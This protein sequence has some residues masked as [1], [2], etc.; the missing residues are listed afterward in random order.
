VRRHRVFADGACDNGS[1]R[2]VSDAASPAPLTAP[3]Q[4]GE[5]YYERTKAVDLEVFARDPAAHGE[6]RKLP[7]TAAS[8]PFADSVD[9][10]RID[11]LT[12]EADLEAALASPRAL[13]LYFIAPWYVG[14]TEVMKQSHA[15]AFSGVLIVAPRRPSS[16]P[17]PARARSTQCA[18]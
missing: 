16:P 5:H 18:C 8:K 4:D 17:P 3:A 14:I 12:S 1:S 2:A 13:L 10:S 9:D 6:V 7:S 11:A 15:H